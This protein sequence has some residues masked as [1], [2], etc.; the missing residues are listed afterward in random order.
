M[1]TLLASLPPR[2]LFLMY[3]LA[4][5]VGVLSGGSW[6]GIGIG[7]ALLMGFCLWRVDGV[8]PMP[9]SRVAALVFAALAWML[10]S[11]LW[12][13]DPAASHWG[14]FKMATILLPLLWLSSPAILD[15]AG[16]NPLNLSWIAVF[17][18]AGFLIFDAGV[19]RL[20]LIDPAQAPVLVGKMN[21]G[22]SYGALLLW[23]LLAG[24]IA[25]GRDRKM[26]WILLAVFGSSFFLT[27]SESTQ[28]GFLAAG[29]LFLL[30]RHSFPLAMA[31][32]GIGSVLSLL[33]PVAASAS[34][35]YFLD[36]IKKLPDSWHMRVEIWDYMSQRIAERPFIGY[37]FS[38]AS[39]VDVSSPNGKYYVFIKEAASHPHNAVLQI[40]GEIG[41]FGLILA[42]ILCFGA[43][44]GAAR[45]PDRLRPY[46]LAAYAFAFCLSL[47]AYH[48]WTDSLWAAFTLTALLFAHL[49]RSEIKASLSSKRQDERESA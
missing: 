44:R 5:S 29:I 33:W 21:R 41:F 7:G 9:L 8:F 13:I 43:L 47:T 28:A 46:A 2:L 19:L 23:P 6:A 37:G 3:A 40:W 34:F 30:A 26:G 12:A 25:L 32:A 17:L 18:C 24:L 1:T 48:I 45:L 39:L 15:R 22:F 49:A 14:V 38:N 16:E 4:A 42:G 27:N 11:S 35:S 10:L 20:L 36:L 31:G